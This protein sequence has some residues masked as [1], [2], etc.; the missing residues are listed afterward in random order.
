VIISKTFTI[1][2]DHFLVSDVVATKHACTPLRKLHRFPQMN[3]DTWMF[4]I[5]KK[6]LTECMVSVTEPTGDLRVR[7]DVVAAARWVTIG[8]AVCKW[9]ETMLK[10]QIAYALQKVLWKCSRENLLSVSTTV[11]G[12]LVH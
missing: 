4:K 6:R 1:R 10:K 11:S 5:T 7:V 8:V 12:G 3:T 2:L 9:P